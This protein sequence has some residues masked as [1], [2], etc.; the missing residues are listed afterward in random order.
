[1][2]QIKLA[3]N[4]RS[5]RSVLTAACLMIAAGCGTDSANNATGP[6]NGSV[7]MTLKAVGIGSASGSGSALSA[8]SLGASFASTSDDTIPVTFTKALLVVHDVRFRLISGGETDT[9]GGE[10]NST[11][12][13]EDDPDAR[14][15]AY[16]LQMEGQGWGHNGN[17]GNGEDQET[18]RFVGPF[19][20]DLLTQT[21]D[22]LDTQM[23]E[24]GTYRNTAGHLRPLRADDW[25]ASSFEYLIGGTVYLQGTVDGPGGDTFTYRAKFYHVFKIKGEFTVEVATPAT[26][27][28]TFDISQWLRGPN[29][30]FLDPR[31]GENGLAIRQAIIRSLRMGM[32]RNHNGRCD[33]RLH[34]E[35]D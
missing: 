19:V 27:F 2:V 1:M 35:Y 21:A 20:V 8:R 11:G 31:D 34:G 25:N 15:E 33:D 32:D 30:R 22:S 13:G 26:A 10:T 18:I 14:D 29:G 28:L 7:P 3:G 23:V 24:P 5:M 16:A 12:A 4:L 6:G 17:G 9:T